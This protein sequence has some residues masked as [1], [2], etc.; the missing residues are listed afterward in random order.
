MLDAIG[1]VEKDCR[2]QRKGSIMK[3][4]V[5]SQGPALSNP[6][7]PRFGRASCFIVLDTETG[8]HHVVDNTQNVNAAQGAG[9]QAAQTVA[10]LKVEAVLTGHCGPKAFRV[11]DAAGIKVYLADEGTV[12]EAVEKLKAGEYKVAQGA[13]VEGHW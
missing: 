10:N 3:V 6:L 5:T 8:Q 11:L 9:V 13:D 2:K 12:E 4:A 7:D 1:V